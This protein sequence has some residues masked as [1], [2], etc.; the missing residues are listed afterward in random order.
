MRRILITALAALLAV[1]LAACGSQTAAPSESSSTSGIDNAKAVFEA[2]SEAMADKK[3]MHVNTDLDMNMTMSMPEEVASED[4]TF[5]M[6]VKMKMDMDVSEL[7]AHGNVDYSM[8]LMGTDSTI[9]AET[10]VDIKNG[11]TYMKESGSDSWTKSDEDFDMEN[12]TMGLE[13]L[14][15]IEDKYLDGAEFEETDGEY[16][17]TLGPDA[18]NALS[19]SDQLEEMGLDDDSSN[20]DI[21]GGP[22]VYHF[23]STT[24]YLK[25]VEIK[26]L[27]MSADVDE[28]D[29]KYSMDILINCNMELS[30]LGEIDEKDVMVPDEVAD[31]AK[32]SDEDMELDDIMDD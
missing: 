28:D 27:K 29:Q 13:D 24:N 25:Y 10:Y 26:D 8:T 19:F 9:T 7:Y 6:P 1:T 31:N 2:A 15:S 12:V 20:I 32:E 21:S 5:E 22:I 3:T 4:S 23:D 14:E 17:V 16:V 11:V 18:V 30:S